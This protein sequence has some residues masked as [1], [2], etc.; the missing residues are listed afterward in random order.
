MAVFTTA[1][2]QWVIDK[3]QDVAPS[4]NAKQDWGAWGTGGGAEAIG[5]TALTTEASEAR[6]AG[7]LSQPA[8]DT[9]RLVFTHTSNGTKTITEGARFNQLAVGGIMQ[10]RALFTGIP[11]I[12][13]DQIQQTHDL[14]E[15]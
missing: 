6:V 1:G 15:T 13:G 2:K 14:Q 9:D 3:L 5:N 11:T 8:A 4:S 7:V 12:A 10:Q